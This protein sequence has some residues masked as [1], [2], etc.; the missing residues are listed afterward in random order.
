M[1][2]TPIITRLTELQRNNAARLRILPEHITDHAEALAQALEALAD[3]ALE[4]S[5]Q[6]SGILLSYSQTGNTYTITGAGITKTGALVWVQN[7][8]ID[9]STLANGTYYLVLRATPRT[10]DRTFTDPETGENITHT[11]A[12]GSG[13]PM[14]VSAPADNDAIL[15]LVTKSGTTYYTAPYRARVRPSRLVWASSNSGIVTVNGANIWLTGAGGNAGIPGSMR[16]LA[17]GVVTATAS[18][19]GWIEVALRAYVGAGAPQTIGVARGYSPGA[20]SGAH[21]SVQGYI[22]LTPGF[23]ESVTVELVATWDG[24]TTWTVSTGYA[25]IIVELEA[26]VP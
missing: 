23:N 1:A 15:G 26:G 2:R 22:V 16:M 8:V 4:Y 9:V 20:S 3:I 18:A 24:S 25:S 11:M 13:V 12:V 21:I 5:A 17:R 7:G 10:A 14:F 19:A 6:G